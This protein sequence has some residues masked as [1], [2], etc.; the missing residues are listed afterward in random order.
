M[1][2]LVLLILVFYFFLHFFQDHHTLNPTRIEIALRDFFV[3]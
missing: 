1:D 2:G 3:D